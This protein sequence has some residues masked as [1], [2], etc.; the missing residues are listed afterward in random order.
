MLACF[1]AEQFKRLKRCDR[2]Y[3]E[4]DLPTTKFAS[5]KLKK[6]NKLL[7]FTHL[8]MFFSSIDRDS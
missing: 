3:Y 4:N 6:I 7:A 1:I 8:T 2:F 5:C